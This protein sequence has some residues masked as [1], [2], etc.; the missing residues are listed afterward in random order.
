MALMA[1]SCRWEKLCRLLAQGVSSLF[2]SLLFSAPSRA[3]ACSGSPCTL[4]QLLTTAR[5]NPAAK[6]IC[7]RNHCMLRNQQ[8][9]CKQTHASKLCC[10]FQAPCPGPERP[11]LHLGLR[12]PT[13]ALRYSRSYSSS[14][15]RCDL[16]VSCVR[17][18]NDC[19][20]KHG[21]RHKGIDQA[22]GTPSAISNS[23]PEL[24]GSC[25]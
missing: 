16:L 2:A 19:L 7:P 5:T 10:C 14:R 8:A 24:T 1:F 4:S 25:P 20:R 23:T 11:S 3:W 21:A 6:C 18:G 9:G 22:F 13:A 15:F 12:R 17:V